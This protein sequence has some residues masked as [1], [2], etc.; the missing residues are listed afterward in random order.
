MIRLLG[1]AT[2][3]NVQKVVF[4]LE[5][6]GLPYRREDYGRQF[7]NTGGEYL[8][9]NPSGKVPTLVDGE[10]VIWESNTI[11]RYLAAKNG[12]PLYPSDPEKRS[13]VERWM[14]WLLA[15]LNAPYVGIF[16]EAKKAPAERAGSWTADAKELATQLQLLDG[17]LAKQPYLAG[18]EFSIADVALAPIV[19]RCLDFPV[20]L[21]AL[22][23]LKAWRERIAARPA[24]RR[25]T[26]A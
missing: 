21:P 2:S 20:D 13:H 7:N 3:G 15:S 23:H 1:R 6:M 17:Q 26:A 5:E 22:P 16:K 25:A 4:L 9:L 18:S 8:R 11:L 10:T 24:F 19:A 12:S 14:D